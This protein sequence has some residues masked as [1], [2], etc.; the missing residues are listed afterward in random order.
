MSIEP[1]YVGMTG[2]SFKIYCRTSTGDPLPQ[3]LT[4]TANDLT[5]LIKPPVGSEFA[6]GGLFQIINPSQG[7]VQYQPAN[8]DVNT[9]GTFEIAVKVQTSNGP[10]YSA[11]TQWIISSR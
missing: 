11:Q 7:I 3:L 5:L 9:S 2:Q 8:S 10:I 4:A 1:W 6:G